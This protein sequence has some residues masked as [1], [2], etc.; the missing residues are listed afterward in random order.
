MKL[1]TYNYTFNTPCGFSGTG[2]M[3]AIN[4]SVVHSALIKEM[5]QH[6]VDTGRRNPT[7][8]DWVSMFECECT[9]KRAQCSIDALW[10]TPERISGNT[11]QT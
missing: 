7:N 11:S 1:K 10:N 9:V 3:T 2:Q 8:S 5:E 4:A 6:L